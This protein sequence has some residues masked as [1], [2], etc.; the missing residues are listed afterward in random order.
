MTVGVVIFQDNK[1]PNRE[2]E[3]AVAATEATAETAVAV[4]RAS[5]TGLRLESNNPTAS[6][7]RA[8]A[9]GWVLEI[10]GQREEDAVKFRPSK[11]NQTSSCAQT[12][13]QAR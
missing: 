4:N 2:I 1:R 11:A 6:S 9:G 5:T 10:K 3:G 13:Q 7:G 12:K 8:T